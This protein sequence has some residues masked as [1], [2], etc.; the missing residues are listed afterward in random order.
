MKRLRKDRKGA[1]HGSLGEQECRAPGTETPSL[2]GSG[3]AWVAGVSVQGQ[4]H[5][6]SRHYTLEAAEPGLRK[7]GS[8]GRMR[9]TELPLQ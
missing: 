4:G 7:G 8:T 9:E 5:G 6:G 1:P 3:E 2:E